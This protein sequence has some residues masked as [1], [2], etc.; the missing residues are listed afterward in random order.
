MSE[1]TTEWLKN[2]ATEADIQLYIEKLRE[3]TQYYK[4][5]NAKMLVV[6]EKLKLLMHGHLEY[7]SIL[8]GASEVDEV[9][10]DCCMLS[11]QEKLR[12]HNYYASKIKYCIK[13]YSNLNEKL[14][15][16]IK[17]LKT[18]V[19]SSKTRVDSINVTSRDELKYLE[20]K[21]KRYENE[22]VKLEK[23]HPW[24]K[25]SQL[26]LPDIAE[27]IEKLNS[28]RDTKKKLLADL[29][30]YEG[31]KPHIADADKQLTEIKQEYKQIMEEFRKL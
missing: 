18:E 4:E 5:E 24:L 14:L 26:N 8:E 22:L 6:I 10:R 13:M 12:K 30:A 15:K 3:R 9:S 16:D 20:A 23:K 28:L 19:D 1:D 7:L 29:A 21:V 25:N 31:L 17:I 27:Q 11:E 2:I